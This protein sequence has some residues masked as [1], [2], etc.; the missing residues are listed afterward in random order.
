MADVLQALAGREN[1]TVVQN[2]AQSFGITP[3]QAQQTLRAVM[4]ELSGELERLTLSRGGLADLVNTMG[5][6]E[7]EQFVDNPALLTDADAREDGTKVLA[8]VFGTKHKSRKV[9][10]RAAKETGLPDQKVKEM[11]PALA[12]LFMGELAKQTRGQIK[13]AANNTEKYGAGSF[14]GRSDPFSGQNPLPMPGQMRGRDSGGGT[15][16]G[17]SNPYEDFSDILR[18]RGGRV[19]KGGSL[20]NVIRDAVGSALGFQSKGIMGWI[21]RMVVMR[22]GWQIAQMFLRRFLGR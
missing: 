20:A 12:G 4:P 18:R 8:E 5:Q 9:A 11:L 14:G 17:G 7:Y 2:L 3:D 21:I 1:G 10:H 13:K 6:A 19:S 15:R 22:Y 16:G